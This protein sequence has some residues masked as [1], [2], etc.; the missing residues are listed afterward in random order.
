VSEGFDYGNARVRA[1]RADLLG[2][3]GYLDLTGLTVDRMLAVLS[4]T[5][6]RRDLEAATPR[7]RGLRLLD[8]ALRTNL[9][10]NLR[11][12]A[13]W[14]EEPAAADV[15]LIVGRWDLRNVRTVL[16]GQYARSEP[17]E[18]RAALVPAG[19]LGDAVLAE[20]ASRPGLR[21]TVEL[22]VSWGV[23]VPE[24]AR[25]A[26]GALAEYEASGDFAAFE[27]ALERAAGRRLDGVLGRAAS[28]VAHVLR[29]EIDDANLLTALR[30]QAVGSATQE[31]DPV[32]PMERFVPGGV[33]A[34]PL[35]A[36]V[37]RAEDRGDAGAVISEASVPQRWGSALA[38]WEVS[39]DL[40]ALSDDIDESLTREAAAMFATADPLGPGVVVAYVWAKENEVKNLR[41]IGAGLAAGLAPDMIEDELVILW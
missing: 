11:E 2:A 12:L 5:A 36:R 37:A 15:V 40:A 9:A 23:P 22:M 19:T 3:A 38:R 20:L 26:A 16:R 17:D 31:W 34:M 6:Y 18:I 21:A 10:R 4:D 27:R 35:L 8:E 28:E 30:L 39:G 25:G 14:Y 32:D 33:L 29:A 7:Y 24:V 1:R 41:T 13:V